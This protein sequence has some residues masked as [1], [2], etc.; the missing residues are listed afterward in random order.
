MESC[1]I[2]KATVKPSDKALR[3]SSPLEFIHFDLCG[4]VKEC[5]RSINS[6]TFIDDY[7]WYGYV[8]LLSYCY[9][10]FDLFKRFIATVET[11][12]E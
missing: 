3:A 7:S 6:F 10:A 4:P 11:Q 12:L 1:L 8:Y 2:R 5:C 9:E